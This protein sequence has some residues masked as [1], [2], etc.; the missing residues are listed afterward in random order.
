MLAIAPQALA[1]DRAKRCLKVAVDSATLADAPGF[2]RAN[3]P[4]SA[5]AGVLSARTRTASQT[6]NPGNGG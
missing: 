3:P 1:Y 4:E 2:D 6:T 5:T